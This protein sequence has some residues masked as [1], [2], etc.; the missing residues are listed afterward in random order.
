MIELPLETIQRLIDFAYAAMSKRP[1]H[2]D[3]YAIVQS[4]LAEGGYA[5]ILAKDFREI[6]K[7]GKPSW[8]KDVS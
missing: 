4:R 3:D 8:E 6:Q 1:D 5:V 2:A 7:L